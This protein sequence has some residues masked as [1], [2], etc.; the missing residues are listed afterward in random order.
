MSISPFEQ[1]LKQLGLS[2]GFDGLRSRLLFLEVLLCRLHREAFSY[3]GDLESLFCNSVSV[4]LS[5]WL[6]A[7]RS[8]EE[9]KLAYYL[10]ISQTSSIMYYFFFLVETSVNIF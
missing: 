10:R 2:W 3:S 6:K 8:P 7:L 1:K 4:S 5:A 9:K